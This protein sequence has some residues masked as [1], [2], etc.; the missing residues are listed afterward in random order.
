MSQAAR[1][2]AI[3]GLPPQEFYPV[4]TL[5][6]VQRYM[7]FKGAEGVSARTQEQYRSRLFPFA[8][9]YP[10]VPTD[11]DEIAR[12]LS[13]LQVDPV[14]R[15]DYRKH[16]IAFYHFLE[17]RREVPEVTNLFPRIKAHRKVR[18]V[19]SPEELGRL[20]AMAQDYEDRAILTLLVD[21][22]IRA[23][24]LC[25]LTREDVY[26][27]HI[28][29]TGKTGQRSVPIKQETADMIGRLASQGPLFKVRGRPM[30]RAVLRQRVRDLM[31][32]SG[33]DGKKLG[34]H[35]LR[36]SS[37]V[38][39]IMFGGDLLSLKE[40]LGH[41]TT[42]MTEQ[43]A[44]LAFKDVKEKHEQVDVLGRLSKKDHREVK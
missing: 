30:T 26:P 36:H 14:T 21:S 4:D 41:S 23:S 24:E 34:P 40:E 16:I 31:L 12:F 9:V 43:Y 19:L 7:S 11:P 20:F 22:K 44:A 38:Q 15:W 29:V 10:V 5:S 6:A 27:D 39:H 17:R 8:K 37:S 35:I 42:R 13:T 2:A 18:R 1:Q 3:P 28:V 32:R 33:L 25:G